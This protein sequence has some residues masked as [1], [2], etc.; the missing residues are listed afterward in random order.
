MKRP[1]KRPDAPGAVQIGVT[2][3]LR[4]VA[5]S[6]VPVRIVGGEGPPR[7]VDVDTGLVDAAAL[8][9]KAHRQSPERIIE[10]MLRRRAGWLFEGKG[11][12]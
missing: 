4:D 1:R 3:Y 12:E 8:L 7:E 10:K 11:G 5:P 6:R 2:T 9:A